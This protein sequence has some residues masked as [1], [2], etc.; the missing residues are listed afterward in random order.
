M[1]L[2]SADVCAL[3]KHADI[4]INALDFNITETTSLQILAAASTNEVLEGLAVQ[5]PNPEGGA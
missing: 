4:F 2:E 5:V 3:R 1:M